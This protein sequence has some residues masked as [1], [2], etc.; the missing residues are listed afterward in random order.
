M[1]LRIP[2]ALWRRQAIF[3]NPNSYGIEGYTLIPWLLLFYDRVVV[4]APASALIETSFK[5]SPD[6]AFTP[7]EYRSAILAGEIIPVAFDTFCDTC[8]RTRNYPL[9]MQ[10]ASEFDQDLVRSST[11]LG[12]HLRSLNSTFKKETSA[13]IA[14]RILSADVGMAQRLRHLEERLKRGD[15]E[16]LPM[17]YQQ[18]VTSRI[19]YPEPLKGLDL[20][21]E[22]H[23]PVMIVYDLLNEKF[24]MGKTGAGIHYACRLEQALSAVHGL[25]DLGIELGSP[26]VSGEKGIV[27]GKPRHSLDQETLASRRRIDRVA[28]QVLAEIIVAIGEIRNTRKDR[29]SLEAVRR[30]RKEFGVRFIEDLGKI[31]YAGVSTEDERLRARKI[32]ENVRSFCR[33]YSKRFQLSP[34]VLLRLLKF[35]DYAAL[36]DAV[37]DCLGQGFESVGLDWSRFNDGLRWSFDLRGR[38]AYWLFGRDSRG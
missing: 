18:L 29:L 38:W 4:Y 26:S 9:E 37:D 24:A 13:Q 8:L 7:D 23:L 14:A 6:S 19:P 34:L 30:F 16:A 5:V 36:S 11:E 2:I 31:M 3:L 22:D 21:P 33:T 10:V 20:A 27:A 1:H 17:R 32:G 15:S 25:D 12:S 35:I 28:T